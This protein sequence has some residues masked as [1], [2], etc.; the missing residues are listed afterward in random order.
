VV[1]IE[2]VE[3]FVPGRLCLIGGVSDLV[4]PYLSQNPELVPGRAI[5]CTIDKGIYSKVKKSNILKYKFN[6]MSFEI[7][8]SRENLKNE[9]N[10]GTFFSYICGTVLC[11][12][13]NHSNLGGIDITVEKMDLPLKKGL[14][15]SA[16]ICL[17]IVKSYN[18]LYDLSL[19][20]DEMVSLAYNGEHLA[21]SKCGKLDQNTIINN[22]CSSLTF[23]E[24]RVESKEVKLK[25]NLFVLIVDLNSSKDTR[26]I[27]NSFNKALPFAKNEKDKR[28][29]DIIGNKNVELVEKA[30][31]SLEHGDIK[32]FGKCLSDAQKLYDAAKEACTEYKAPT[33]HLLL[34]DGF[35]K[36]YSYG[37]KSV[38]SGGDGSLLLVCD[39]ESNQ[40]T[41]QEYIKEIYKMESIPFCIKGVEK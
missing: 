20:N 36:Y 9:A 28:I 12:L 35:I 18:I 25:N 19:N 22:N 11:I 31:Y 14:S 24:D 13:E 7:D 29:H 17:T 34:N 39:N 8:L 2:E 40:N 37:G 26:K 1:K 27:M 6:N 23:Y 33:L 15:S 4:S 10:S 21:G 3:I 16:A 5:A 38:G 32:L 30:I 41:L